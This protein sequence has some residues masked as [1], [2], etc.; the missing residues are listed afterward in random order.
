M[1]DRRS[2]SLS[3]DVYCFDSLV[4]SEIGELARDPRELR[5]KTA[6]RC[7]QLTLTFLN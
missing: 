5:C 7:A 4:L 6:E 3:F 1:F 2:S